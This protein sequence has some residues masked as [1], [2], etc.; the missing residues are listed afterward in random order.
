M[1]LCLPSIV[2]TAYFLAGALSGPGDARSGSFC[3]EP[4]FGCHVLL[5]ILVFVFAS[6]YWGATVGPIF[7]PFAVWPCVRLTRAA[8]LGSRLTILGWTLILLGVLAP[9][10]FWS[11]LIHLDLFI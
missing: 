4:G 11:W 1:V 9:V 6:C 5:A 8:G 3:A 7:L 10:V 2:G